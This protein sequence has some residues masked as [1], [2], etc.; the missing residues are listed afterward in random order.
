MPLTKT[1]YLRIETFEKGADQPP[2]VA[3]WHI[4]PRDAM[5]NVH[6]VAARGGCLVK[7]FKTVEDDDVLANRSEYL[8]KDGSAQQLVV[9]EA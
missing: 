2:R 5:K 1:M 6:N 7:A 4:L 9:I 8:T 3:Y